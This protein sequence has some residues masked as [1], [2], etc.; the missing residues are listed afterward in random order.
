MAEGKLASCARY[1][2]IILNLIFWIT[3]ML[4]LGAGIWV[5]AS[6]NVGKTVTEWLR[7]SIPADTLMAV[8]YAVV[9]VGAFMFLIGFCGC[10]GAIRESAIML[11]VYMVFMVV[12]LCGELAGIVYVALEKSSIE[13]NLRD[14]LLSDMLNSTVVHKKNATALDILQSKGKCCGADNFTNYKENYYFKHDPKFEDYSVPDSCC[15]TYSISQD[16]EPAALNRCQ[17]EARLG[18]VN[19]TQLFTKGC[20]N[21]IRD[22]IEDNSAIL[23]GVSSGILVLE[24]IGVALAIYL[25]RNRSD[26]YDD[27]YYD[28]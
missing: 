20:L 28:D 17:M 3:G 24:L 13:T 23:I 1:L 7:I 26:L 4:L 2:L 21:I 27:D 19:G 8:G 14:K 10:C 9:G 22:L 12:L 25:C 18:L 5:V 15:L 11:G 16:P 6:D